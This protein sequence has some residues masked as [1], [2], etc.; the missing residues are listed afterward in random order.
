MQLNC[1]SDRDKASPEKMHTTPIATN[2]S[3]I[4][5]RLKEMALSA[6][7]L[8]MNSPLESTAKAN[9]NSQ[10]KADIICDS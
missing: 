10:V 5:H 3:K 2:K 4:V 6:E 7:D 9:W 1:I 8:N